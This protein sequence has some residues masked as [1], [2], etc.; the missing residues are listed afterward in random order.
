VPGLRHCDPGAIW[1][2]ADSQK[3]QQ[4]SPPSCLFCRLLQ[5]SWAET[6][7]ASL[8]ILRHQFITAG[9]LKYEVIVNKTQQ[10]VVVHFAGSADVLVRNQSK[11]RA[12]ADEDVR[13]PGIGPSSLRN[14]ATIQ[15]ADPPS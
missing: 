13:V 6:R 7:R 11:S 14:G 4:A 1:A 9:V 3:S 12:G 5:Q 8:K 10:A 15:Q 2:E